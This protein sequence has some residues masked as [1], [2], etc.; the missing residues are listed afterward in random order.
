MFT[1]S[2]D[3]LEEADAKRLCE[4]CLHKQIL[5]SIKHSLWLMWP[6]TQPE[7]EQRQL[8]ASD[9]QPDPCTEFA[10]VY[11]LILNFPFYSALMSY[12]FQ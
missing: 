6:S 3:N 12:L 8:P 10:A 9:P 4:E 5:D 2:V 11:I 1:N 7:G